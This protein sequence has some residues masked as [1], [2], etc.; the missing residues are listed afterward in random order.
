MDAAAAAAAAAAVWIDSWSL[1]CLRSVVFFACCAA[2]DHSRG[3]FKYF[4]NLGDR[5]AAHIYES[6]SDGAYSFPAS[7]KVFKSWK[8]EPA[9]YGSDRNGMQS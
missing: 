3:S 6:K 4:T 2:S 5:P 7:H 9:T 8:E 1:R